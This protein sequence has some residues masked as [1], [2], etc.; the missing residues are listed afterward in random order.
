MSGIIKHECGI[1]F[2]RLRKPL[3]FYLDKYKS[4]FYA[5]NKMFL[6]MHKQRN[7]GQ[8]GSGIA[9]IKMNLEPG[10]KYINRYRSIQNDSIQV[11][12][13]KINKKLSNCM[14]KNE[15]KKWMNSKWLKQNISFS[16]ELWL[17]HLRYGTFGKN[18]IQNCAPTLRQNNW[19]SRNLILAGNFNMTNLDHLFNQLI[20]IGQ[21]PKEKSDTVTIL[22][23]IG[24]LLDEE[25]IRIFKKYQ[26]KFS[27]IEISK[28]IEKEIDIG[29]V[30]E[31]S[32]KNFDGG[33]ALSGLIGNGSAFLVR[34]PNG[35]RPIYYYTDS[36]VIV[37]TSER[38]PIKTA[39]ECEYSRIKELPPGHALIVNV[40]GSFKIKKILEPLEKKACSFERIYFSRGSDPEIYKERKKLGSL[41]VPQILKSID[42]NYRD[43]IFS[44]VPN[45]SETCFYGLIDSLKDDLNKRRLDILSKET[46]DKES[47]KEI[48]SLKV[49][50]ETL[51]SKDIKMRTFIASDKGRGNLV[52]NIYDTTF[53]IVNSAK[54]SIVIIDDSIVRGTTLEKSI[55][56][57]LSKLKAKK[58]VFVSSSPQIRYPDC[59]GIDMSKMNQFVAFRA[60]IKL[61]KDRKM[62]SHIK[63]TYLKCKKSLNAKNPINHVKSLYDLFSYE[64]ISDKISE[65]IKPKFMNSDLKII[66]QTIENLN[67]ACPNHLGDWYFTGNYPTSGGNR[68]ANQAFINFVEGKKTRAY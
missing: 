31:N 55:L 64:E 21:S 12:F 50:M 36:E 44:Y 5:A 25:N 58:V 22:E 63:K 9:S 65:I 6:L 1:A 54:D 37:A 59:Y 3:Q 39:F 52:S 51:I 60:L 61:I 29:Y 40:D 28:K 38:P 34:D 16:G 30:L 62:K 35:I 23:K 13:N 26:N 68:V 48:M 27:K 57:L 32:F 24:H 14:N 33:Y 41:L 10:T 66:Y 2:M 17:G 53:Q 42:S 18:S 47:L 19:K 20:D 11:I 15:S 45:T 49:R 46:T 8:D 4:I 7:R 56:S 67:K 43:T